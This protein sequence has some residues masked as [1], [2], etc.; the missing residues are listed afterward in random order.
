MDVSDSELV[1]RGRKGD[2][3]ALQLLV[4]RYQRRV[5]G[6]VVGMVRNPEDAREIVQETFVRA[7]RNL[8]SFKGDSSFYTWLYRIAFNLAVDVQRRDAKRTNVEF[9]EMQP[10]EDAPLAMGGRTQGRDPFETVR[11]RE[12]GEKIFRAID[13]LTPDHRAVI[14][15]REIDGLSYEEISQALGCSMGTVMSRLH[16]ARKKLQAKLRELL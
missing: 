10:P 4:E 14:L 15:L 12:L 13:S 11:N 8:D 16:Y 6:V 7:F 5:L 3:R 2:R 9:D 1:E